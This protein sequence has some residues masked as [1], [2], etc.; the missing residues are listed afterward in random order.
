MLVSLIQGHGSTGD[1]RA[2]PFYLAPEAHQGKSERDRTMTQGTTHGPHGPHGPQAPSPW[3][4]QWA[5]DVPAGAPV[6]DLACGGGRHGRYF[7]AHGHPVTFLDRDVSALADLSAGDGTAAEILEADL[8]TGCP[9]PLRERRFGAV[10][11][12]N[13]LWRPI[14]GDI[15]RAVAPG[16]LLLYETFMAGNEAF[17]RPRNPDHLL[18]PGELRETFAG[19][20]EILAFEEGRIDKPAP[21]MKQ[22]LAARRPA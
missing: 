12:V 3:I 14:M 13:Y 17:G 16:G 20:L 8:E 5:D 15:A 22:W 10:V 19:S 1:I 2:D 7:L 21:A 18:Q 4:L 11:V 9:F 6:L